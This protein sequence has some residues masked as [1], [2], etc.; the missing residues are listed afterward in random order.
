MYNEEV[1]T[2]YT[3]VGRKEQRMHEKT[4][5]RL[6]ALICITGSTK[7]DYCKRDFKITKYKGWQKHPLQQTDC[8]KWTNKIRL[9]QPQ[10]N[11]IQIESKNEILK[12]LTWTIIN[13]INDQ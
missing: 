8:F 1:Q 12:Q 13:L 11:L 6:L 10:S 2:E 4:H 5:W 3:P 9:A 7:F